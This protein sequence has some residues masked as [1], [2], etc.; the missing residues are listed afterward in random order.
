MRILW[1]YADIRGGS[2]D[3]GHHMRIGSSKIAKR[4]VARYGRDKLS[5]RPSVTLVDCDNTRWN[6]SKIISCVLRPIS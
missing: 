3:M 2:L 6:S 4:S 5:V 1:G